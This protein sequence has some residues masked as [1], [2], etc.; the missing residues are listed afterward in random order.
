ME[1]KTS[2]EICTVGLGVQLNGA[3]TIIITNSEW[4]FRR[5]AYLHS[6]ILSKLVQSSVCPQNGN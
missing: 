6:E 1:G 5:N 2:D 3:I 4:L